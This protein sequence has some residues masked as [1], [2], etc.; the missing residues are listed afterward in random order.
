MG[1]LWITFDNS[2]KSH[3]SVANRGRSR[4]KMGGWFAVPTSLPGLLTGRFTLK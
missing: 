3:T 4:V 2:P 1:V